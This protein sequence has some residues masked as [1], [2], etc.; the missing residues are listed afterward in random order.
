LTAA[1]RLCEELASQLGVVDVVAAPESHRGLRVLLPDT[2][3][4]GAQMHRLQMDGDPS[5]LDQLY[6]RVGDLLAEATPA[7]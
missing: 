6:D 3:H 5:G 1:V 2:A 4:P 7:R